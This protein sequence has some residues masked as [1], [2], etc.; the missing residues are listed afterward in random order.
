VL[1]ELGGIDLGDDVPES[2][3]EHVR[4]RLGCE[5]PSSMGARD[6]F[7]SPPERAQRV[8]ELTTERVREVR[9]AVFPH[10]GLTP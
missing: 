2:W 9:E 10:L 8:L 3:R 5:P 4:V 1:A 7:D 6:R